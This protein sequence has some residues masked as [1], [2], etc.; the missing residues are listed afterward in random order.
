MSYPVLAEI[1]VKPEH[2][3]D[4]VTAV[5]GILEITR[6]EAGCGQFAL[7]RAADGSSRL[8]IYERWQ[9]RAAFDSHHAQPYVQAIYRSYESWLAGP[10]LINEL[11]DVD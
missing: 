1:P 9:D 10:V 5:S 11:V 4:A 6:A 7:H 8:F 2:L 3:E